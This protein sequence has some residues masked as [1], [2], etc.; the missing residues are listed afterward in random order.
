MLEI[1]WLLTGSLWGPNTEARFPSLPCARSSSYYDP[2]FHL[3][4]RKMKPVQTP[5]YQQ[6]ISDQWVTHRNCVPMATQTDIIVVNVSCVCAYSIAF[7]LRSGKTLVSHKS[8]TIANGTWV[9]NGIGNSIQFNRL[10]MAFRLTYRMTDERIINHF[11]M[12]D[13][14]WIMQQ[15]NPEP[16][17]LNSLE[18]IGHQLMF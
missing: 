3:L 4:N 11:K 6:R 18:R 7:E 2:P 13:D 1:L 15:W 14:C 9:A 16:L 12:Q 17:S 5:K 8:Y 10:Y